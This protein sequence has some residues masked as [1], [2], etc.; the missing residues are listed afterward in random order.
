LKAV[1]GS[2]NRSTA[3]VLCILS[4]IFMVGC[5]E[6]ALVFAEPTID[7]SKK[8]EISQTIVESFDKSY[9]SVD[10]LKAEFENAISDFE[11]SG[12]NAGEVELTDI[13][14]ENGKV[15]VSL[16]FSSYEADRDFQGDDIYYGTVNDAYDAGYTLDVTLKSIGDGNMI[17]KNELMGMKDNHILILPTSGIV[18]TAY[19]IQ[20]VSANVEMIDE[21]SV[22]V[23]SDSDG[24]AY[25]VMK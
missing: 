10:E 25:I 16:H 21:K 7:V 3:I 5:K 1:K 11:N 17:G 22:R 15:F 20:Y 13:H 8:G 12:K 18:N 19:K 6:E 4:L 9:Y 24:L 23:S 2:I 14:L